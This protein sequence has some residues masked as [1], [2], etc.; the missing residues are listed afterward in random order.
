MF[1]D[2]LNQQPMDKV[3][4]FFEYDIQFTNAGLNY[5]FLNVSCHLQTVS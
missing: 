1:F 3:F 2:I 4:F 5:M